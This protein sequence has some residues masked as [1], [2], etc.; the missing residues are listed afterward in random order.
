MSFCLDLTLVWCLDLYRVTLCKVKMSRQTTLG[1][2]GSACKTM[3][4]RLKT[5]D[6]CQVQTK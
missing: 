5:F 1:D 4:Q 3:E 6:R 2:E